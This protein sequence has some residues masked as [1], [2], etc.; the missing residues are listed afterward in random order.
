MFGSHDD[1]QVNKYDKNKLNGST[2]TCSMKNILIEMSSSFDWLI[3][4]VL[5][6]SNKYFRVEMNI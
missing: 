6:E 1:R 3:A 5:N 4:N 2:D